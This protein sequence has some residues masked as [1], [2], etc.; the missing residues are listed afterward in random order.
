M[1]S[2]HCMQVGYD[3]QIVVLEARETAASKKLARAVQQSTGCRCFVL[4]VRAAGSMPACPCLRALPDR[5]KHISLPH[6]PSMQNAGCQSFVLQAALCL[7]LLPA[8]AASFAPPVQHKRTTTVGNACSRW[9]PQA[10]FLQ[11]PLIACAASLP[12]HFRRSQR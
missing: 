10:A 11:S 5:Q 8:C 3:T 12:H 2:Q 4:Q 7:L 9:T 6:Q 1:L